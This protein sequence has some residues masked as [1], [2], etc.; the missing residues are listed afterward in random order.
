MSSLLSNQIKERTI[1]QVDIDAYLALGLLSP[2][3]TLSCYIRT[4]LASLSPV[5]VA[6]S[7]LMG[8][9]TP[10]VFHTRLYS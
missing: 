3:E 2:L 10:T 6:P 5:S 4:T 8:L 1:K 7:R 9:T